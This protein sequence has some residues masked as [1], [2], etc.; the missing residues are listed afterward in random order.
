[1][2]LDTVYNFFLFIYLLLNLDGM[3]GVGSVVSETCNTWTIVDIYL[4]RIL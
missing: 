2:Y 4:S 3:R 1:M